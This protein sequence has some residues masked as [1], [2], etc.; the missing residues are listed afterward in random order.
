MEKLTKQN[1]KLIVVTVLIS[2][3]FIVL[4]IAPLVKILF[5]ENK[6]ERLYPYKLYLSID[7]PEKE[8][9]F[10][11]Y[12]KEHGWTYLEEM[13]SGRIYRKGNSQKYIGVS[14]IISV[15]I[16]KSDIRVWHEM[17]TKISCSKPTFYIVS[18]LYVSPIFLLV[19]L[20]KKNKGK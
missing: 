3:Y 13:E 8:A 15:Y 20:Y 16:N 18:L 11:N 9:D 6:V 14:D 4:P 7:L 19:F 12:M 2:I 17:S 5:L 1:I 10:E